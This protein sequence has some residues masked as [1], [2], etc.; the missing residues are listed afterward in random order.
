M[1]MRETVWNSLWREALVECS[2]PRAT[3]T[4]RNNDDD[5]DDDDDEDDDDDDDEDNARQ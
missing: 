1:Q 5:D 2:G 3:R 4:S